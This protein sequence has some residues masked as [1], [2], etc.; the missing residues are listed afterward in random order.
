MKG[1]V[2]DNHSLSLCG[3]NCELCPM[4]LDQYCPGCGGGEGN[5]SCKIARCSL[6]HDR[7]QYCFDCAHY[8]CEKYDHADD[9]DSFITHKHRKSD[10]KRAID[11]GISAYTL[12]QKE[13]SKALRYLLDH[14]NDGRKK[15]FFCLAVNLLEIE[16]VR[17]AMDRISRF[18]EENPLLFLKEMSV[19]AC[20]VFQNIAGERQI[21]LKL[22]RKK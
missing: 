21:E 17:M 16:D 6:E 19:Y 12:E 5:Q 8:P 13:R 15:T 20:T 9:Y 18:K 3:L 10:I 2:R 4:L 22:R 7:V 14:F 1:F 11:L